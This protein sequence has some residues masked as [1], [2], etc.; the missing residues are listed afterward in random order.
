MEQK[1]TEKV[2]KYFQ[3]TSRFEKEQIFQKLKM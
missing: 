3:N 1:K 2:I